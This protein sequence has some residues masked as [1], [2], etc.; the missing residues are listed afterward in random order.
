M[1]LPL[2][3]H[4]QEESPVIF[5]LSSPFSAEDRTAATDS[6]EWQPECQTRVSSIATQTGANCSLLQFHKTPHSSTPGAT[7]GKAAAFG[8]STAGRELKKKSVHL[9]LI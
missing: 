6:H 7:I 2:R 8:L 5:Q 9:R 1:T 3:P 4:A